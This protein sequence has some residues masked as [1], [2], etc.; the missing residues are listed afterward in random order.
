MKEKICGE[1]DFSKKSRKGVA[2]TIICTLTLNS[3]QIILTNHHGLEPGTKTFKGT[4]CNVSFETFTF[5]LVSFIAIKQEESIF[6]SNFQ[7]SCTNT[8]YYI[9]MVRKVVPTSWAYLLVPGNQNSL[10]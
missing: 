4:A 8:F 9:G 6:V 1:K 7:N 2:Q 3:K 10:N 5:G